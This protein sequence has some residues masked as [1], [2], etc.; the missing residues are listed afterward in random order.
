MYSKVS[1]RITNLIIILG[2]VCSM[3]SFSQTSLR[4]IDGDLVKAYKRIIND[5][6]DLRYDSFAPAFER[7]LIKELKKPVTFENSLDSLSKYI[8]VVKSEDGKIK[9]YSWDD[10]T[11]GT[12]HHIN[13]IAQFKSGNG[14]VMVHQLNGKDPY[15]DSQIYK[16][17]QINSGL[18]I[19]Y[20][21]LGAGTYGNGHE[22]RI[23]QIF[24]ITDDKLEK[25]NSCFTTKGDLIIVYARIEKA[26]LAF[27]P[28]TLQL[29]YNEFKESDGFLL[30]TGKIITLKFTNGS[31]KPL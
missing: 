20:L 2:L 11:G 1:K 12:W 7:Q 23:V 10:L 18:K 25:C 28:K 9:F 27:D 29:S 31:F 14:K 30:S 6:S 21:T 4:K 15:S 16:V 26:N 22:H 17:Y 3:N 8:S 19:S 24:F 5:D 13:C